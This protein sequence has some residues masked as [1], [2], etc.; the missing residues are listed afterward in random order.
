MDKAAL[1]E[2]HGVLTDALS[3]LKYFSDSPMELD[4]SVE[5]QIEVVETE[6]AAHTE[7]EVA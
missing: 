7:T 6:I 4:E 3:F 2:L 1:Q 5:K